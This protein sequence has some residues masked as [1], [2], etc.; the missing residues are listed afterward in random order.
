MSEV[1]SNV[2]RY[3]RRRQRLLNHL[4]LFVISV[5]T[6]AG[7]YFVLAIPYPEESSWIFRW[8]LAT[9]YAA[10]VLLA[11]TLSI[12]AWNLL[13]KG[14]SP[15]SVDLRR[16]IGIW[17]GLFAIAHTLVGINVHMK[18]WT[19]Y[20]VDDAGSLRTDFF[21]LANYLGLLAVVIVIALLATSNDRSLALLKSRTWKR[22][23]RWSYLFAALTAAHALLYIAV[24]NRFVPY[25]F[26]LTGLVLWVLTAQLI[27]VLKKGRSRKPE[28]P[29]NTEAGEG[30]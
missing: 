28:T 21:G 19:L 23:Q 6:T 18:N 3:R 29:V 12:G 13:R 20:F 9:A 25:L 7:L 8:S 10:S 16:D 5:G 30:T 1:P 17:C 27:G 24:E 14:S 2:S 22:V 4:F 15:L 26:I 11:A